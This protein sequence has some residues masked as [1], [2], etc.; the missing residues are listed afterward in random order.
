MEDKEKKVQL[1]R[2]RRRNADMDEDLRKL[3]DGVVYETSGHGEA[4]TIVQRP[5]TA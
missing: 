3:Q 5:S 1:M 2:L 4:D